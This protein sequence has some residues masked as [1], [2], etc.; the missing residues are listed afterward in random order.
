MRESMAEQFGKKVRYLRRQQGRTQADVSEALSASG[1]HISNI[2]AGRKAPS[3]D[4]VIRIA[5]IFR[6]TTDYLMRD[7]IPVESPGAYITAQD[8]KRATVLTLSGA[9]LRYLRTQR[10]MHQADLARQLGL[11]T[12]AHISLL[13]AGHK[14]PSIN[15]VLRIA[16]LFG[17]TTD[18]LLRDDIP[19]SLEKPSNE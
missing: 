6:V 8:P 11:R 2:E 3:L 15:L 17:V 5:D 12:Q 19:V 7:D 9:K 18:Y 10:N 13:E 14:E 1:S 4:T 16:D